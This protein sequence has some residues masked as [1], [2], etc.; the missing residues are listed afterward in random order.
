MYVAIYVSP[1][2]KERLIAIKRERGLKNLDET[3]S[4]LTEGE[5]HAGTDNQQG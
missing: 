5:A 4:L 2:V 1:Q 3:L